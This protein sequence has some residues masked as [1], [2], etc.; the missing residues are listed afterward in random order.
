M[1]QHL[2]DDGLE[3][4]SWEQLEKYQNATTTNLGGI[5][6]FADNGNMSMIDVSVYGIVGS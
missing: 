4:I 5:R 3:D 1:M 6:F 2:K